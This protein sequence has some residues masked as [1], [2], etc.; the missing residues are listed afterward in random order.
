MTDPAIRNAKVVSG[1]PC[2][3]TGED[4]WIK[5]VVVVRDMEG[6]P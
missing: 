2:G 5:V 6:N 4:G 3:P 1:I